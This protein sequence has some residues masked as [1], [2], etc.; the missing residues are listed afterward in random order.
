MAQADTNADERISRAELNA[1]TDA[2]FDKLDP[3]KTGRVSQADFGARFASLTPPARRPRRSAGRGRSGREPA[4][5]RSGPS[6][7][8]SSAATS[9]TTGT[10][11]SSSR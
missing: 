6:G 3:E 7:T 1:L 5:S 2:W 8:P 9:S 4:A 10:I 11:R